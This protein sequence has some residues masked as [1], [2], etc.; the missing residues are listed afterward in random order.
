MSGHTKH[1]D[2]FLDAEGRLTRFPAKQKMQ[3]EALSYLAEKLEPGRVYTEPEINDLLNEWHTFRD[4]ATL[5]RGL[6]NAY[7]LNR[8]DDGSRYTVPPKEPELLPSSE[9]D[10]EA[11]HLMLRRH[12]RQFNADQETF[13]FHIKQDGRLVAGITACRVLDTM[14]IECLC[15]DEDFRGKGYGTR[16][17]RRIEDIAREKHLRQ[18][19]VWTYSFQAPDFYGKL[20]Y[21]RL[22][23]IAPCYGGYHQI[24]FRKLLGQN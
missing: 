21:E 10:N 14:E 4:P 2:S 11:L 22:F 3:L 13:A 20:G 12:N 19:T 16:L 17:M 7:L 1:L 5:R 8:S 6:Y 18:I 15:V 9:Q 24:F 23:T